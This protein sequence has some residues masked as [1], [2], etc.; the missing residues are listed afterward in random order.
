MIE[1]FNGSGVLHEVASFLDHWPAARQMGHR[2]K[3]IFAPVLERQGLKQ[4]FKSRLVFAVYN[5]LEVVDLLF[6]QFNSIHN[7]AEEINAAQIDLKAL[8]TQSLQ[9]FNRDE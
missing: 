4:R 1:C 6:G 5:F 8:D 3:N 9:L 7:P 2:T